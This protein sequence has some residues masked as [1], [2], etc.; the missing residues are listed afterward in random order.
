[1]LA[2]TALFC[3]Q[4]KRFLGRKEK[5]P[6]REPSYFGREES[7]RRQDAAMLFP[8]KPEPPQ[9]VSTP[10]Y[11]RNHARESAHSK[12]IA[13]AVICDDDSSAVRMAVHMMA[14]ACPYEL[15]SIPVE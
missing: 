12:G 10:T 9:I 14:A 15:K 4:F 6:K 5:D 7:L 2:G 3:P 11:V 1:L 13:H 8:Q